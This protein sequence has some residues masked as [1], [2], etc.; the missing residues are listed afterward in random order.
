MVVGAWLILTPAG[1]LSAQF[2]GSPPVAPAP[3]PPAQR[4]K[5]K[6]L[7]ISPFPARTHWTL[8][9][10]NQLTAPPAFDAGFGY[11]PIE[12]ERIVAY[13]LTPGTQRWI[14]PGTPLSAPAIG[15]GL[16]FLDQ[17]GQLTALRT[18]DGSTAWT[19]PHSETLVVPLVW[20]HG[21][22]IAVTATEV[23]A[24]RAN[25][26]SLAW[27]QA[28]AGVRAAPALGADAIYLSLGDGRVVALR[29]DT[30][31][32]RWERKLG[33]QPNELLALDDG[34]FVGSTDNYLYCLDPVV[35]AIAWRVQTGADIVSKPAFDKDRVYFVS[36]DNVLR[37]LN[38]SNGVQQ[39]K[40][41][42]PFRPLW[43]PVVAADAL[44]VSGVVGPPRAFLMKDGA[45]AGE[46]ATTANTPVALIRL[47]AMS[48]IELDKPVPPGLGP[49]VIGVLPGSVPIDL[50]PGQEPPVV[51]PEPP[52]FPIV[53]GSS[54]MVAAPYAFQANNTLGPMVIVVRRTIAL[55][56][57]VAAVSRLIEPVPTPYAPPAVAAPPVPVRGGVAPPPVV[58]R[59]LI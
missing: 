55:G 56:A 16:L 6:P 42:L 51:V 44:V 22:L 11:F 13:D 31:A 50:L 45:L 39:W 20:D 36:L 5:S 38:R 4:S 18:S 19:I 10:H 53:A 52:P 59:P 14:A 49:E 3:P 26:G 7:P 35:G 1:I 30:G 21:W 41:P 25:D 12:G 33:G 15:D 17:A 27:R 58:P 47:V 40:R 23:I 43:S 28:V 54:E 37:A 46:F 2:P 57:N 48:L 34:I 29:L 8:A 9:L 24:L 32:M